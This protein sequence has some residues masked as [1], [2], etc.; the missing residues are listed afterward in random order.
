MLIVLNY[1][2]GYRDGI[3][4]PYLQGLKAL[5]PGSFTDDEIPTGKIL[6]GRIGDTDSEFTRPKIPMERESWTLDGSFL[7]FRKLKQ[8]VPEFHEF[9]EKNKLP[10]GNDQLP[11]KLLSP[12]AELLGARLVGRWRSGK[13]LLTF[14]DFIVY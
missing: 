8:L 12:G 2:F 6:C 7:C 11:D 3:A 1:S 5:S 13:F 14:Y 4:Q 10:T 9:L